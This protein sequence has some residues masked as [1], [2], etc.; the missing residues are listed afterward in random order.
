MSMQSPE[1]GLNRLPRKN[2]SETADDIERKLNEERIFAALKLQ[3]KQRLEALIEK[4]KNN[5]K[6]MKKVHSGDCYW[7]NALFVDD[8]ELNVHI[9]E[10]VGGIRAIMYYFLGLSLSKILDLPSGPTTI[11]AF[12]Q[13]LEEWEYMFA[14][15]PMQGMKYVMA[16]S[17]AYAY[18]QFNPND[19]DVDQIR[20]AIYKFN[21]DVVYEHLQYP[22]VPFD[23][24]Y[25]EVFHGLCDMLHSLYDK[26]WHED[27]FR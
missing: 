21:N 6:Y 8:M 10:K 1:A 20:S 2:S 11:R 26:L 4:R 7:L 15:V 25:L 12:A 5:F 9:K 27:A 23:L 16:R 14:S 18:P 24:D 13:L 22:H 19:G 17:S 3:R